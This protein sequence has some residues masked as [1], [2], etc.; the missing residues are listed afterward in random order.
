MKNNTRYQSNCQCNM[1]S[2][3]Y[4]GRI[5][6][7]EVFLPFFIKNKTDTLQSVNVVSP[8]IRIIDRSNGYDVFWLV[9][10]IITV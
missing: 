9:V 5:I 4:T 10:F 6:I 1:P 3:L 8:P 7:N 2:P